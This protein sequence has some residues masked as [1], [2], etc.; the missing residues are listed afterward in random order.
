MAKTLFNQM[1][2]FD[3]QIRVATLFCFHIAQ[4]LTDQFQTL[5]FLGLFAVHSLYFLLDTYGLICSIDTH[6]V[7]G[8][9][10]NLREG[11]I[12]SFLSLLQLSLSAFT[13]A[14]L[15]GQ[16][17]LKSGILSIHMMPIVNQ[18]YDFLTN[19]LYRSA[20]V[21]FLSFTKQQLE[22]GKLNPISKTLTKPNTSY[23]WAFAF[24]FMTLLSDYALVSASAAVP[25]IAISIFYCLDII[26]YSTN[27]QAAC[28][29]KNYFSTLV[30]GFSHC[31]SLL[32]WGIILKT[33]I[34]I[35]LTSAPA[36][37]ANQILPLV[38]TLLQFHQQ[39]GPNHIVASSMFAAF[40]EVVRA[41]IYH[42][43]NFQPE[44][45]LAATHIKSQAFKSKILRDESKYNPCH[46]IER[47]SNYRR[48][49]S[50]EKPG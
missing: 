23:L 15:F 31:M 28:P 10:R 46:V 6:W 33:A 37:I 7:N 4:A 36:A 8:E 14:C 30:I 11:L 45:A 43:M 5:L 44:K 49:R 19:E 38:P 42:A 9:T 20:Y 12:D 21:F 26:A 48:P 35:F 13:A 22:A 1:K 16:T 27:K 41:K 40:S 50:P 39:V 2:K 25:F 3:M 18:Y 34:G 29:D 17:L 24:V 47:N 32:S